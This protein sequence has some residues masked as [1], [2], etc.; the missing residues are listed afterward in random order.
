MMVFY[1]KFKVMTHSDKAIKLLDI[2]IKCLNQVK[3]SFW[4][5]SGFDKNF[6]I[7]YINGR[8]DRLYIILALYSLTRWGRVTHIYVS[9]LTIIASDNGLSPGWHQTIIWTNN[10]E[11]LTR[12]LGTKCREILIGNQTFSLKMH[13]KLSSAKW[14][15]FYLAHNVLNGICPWLFVRTLACSAMET[16][17]NL[18]FHS[19]VVERSLIYFGLILS[20]HL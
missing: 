16:F 17:R 7:F 15:A 6:K 20:I 14:Q 19:I 9:K 18:H 5:I 2:Y 10:G 3:K 11:L 13:L 12:P 8:H 4:S 1:G